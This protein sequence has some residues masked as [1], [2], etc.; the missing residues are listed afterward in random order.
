VSYMGMGEFAINDFEVMDDLFERFIPAHEE[1]WL[2]GTGVIGTAF[3]NYL[4]ECDVEPAG[5]VVSCPNKPVGN[6]P[7]IDIMEFRRRYEAGENMGLLL[8]VDEKYY[9]EVMPDLMFLGEDI[10]FLKRLYKALAVDRCGDRNCIF[11]L[12]FLIVDHCNLSCFSCG[13]SQPCRRER[14]L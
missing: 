6:K 3:Y 1:I 11:H 14:V 5:F 7:V 12:A 2:F 13:C 10:R 4:K 8:T 9:D